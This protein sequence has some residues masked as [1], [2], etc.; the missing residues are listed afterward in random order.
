MIDAI[1]I[2]FLNMGFTDMSVSQDIYKSTLRVESD[3]PEGTSVGTA[4]W[5][6]FVMEGGGKIVPLLVTN[7]HVVNGATEVRLHLN[8][9]DSANPEIKFYNLTI[10]EGAKAFI[11]HPDDNVDICI[12][13]IAGLLN[14]MEKSGIRPELFFFSDRQ[15]RG[16]NYITPVEDVYMTGYPNGLWD[17]VNNRPVTRK[18]ITASSPMENWKGKPEFL[19]DMACFG[20]SSGSPVY[21]MNQG[22]Y[23]TND[24]IAMGERLI[25]LG[26]LYAGPVTNVSGNIE[27][28]DVPTVATPVVRSEITM[29]LGLVI[30][31]EKL[32]DFKPL[33]GL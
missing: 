18:G 28:I 5:F 27:I 16:N 31:A 13:P 29:N 1:L 11:M 32:N 4:F 3:T 2:P 7:K 21:I 23:A 25:F 14:E 26:L 19:I 10:P 6:C 33:L 12:L 15:M 24:G 9:T 20:G 22:S 30:K 17:S 8:I